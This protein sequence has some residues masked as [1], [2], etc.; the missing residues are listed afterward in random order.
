MS[1]RP[2]GIFTKVICD[3]CGAEHPTTETSPTLAWYDAVLHHGWVPGGAF[4]PPPHHPLPR[5]LDRRPDTPWSDMSTDIRIKPRR[6]RKAP[7]PRTC[8]PSHTDRCRFGRDH[9]WAGP[10][11]LDGGKPAEGHIWSHDGDVRC[12][13][14][15]R[16]CTAERE[17]DGSLA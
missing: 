17:T 1:L 12:D 14:C 9:I 2:D 8:C 13:A 10:F 7:A 16:V 5:L 3:T 6:T 15:G 11:L 4:S